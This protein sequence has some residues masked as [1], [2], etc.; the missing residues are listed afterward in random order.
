MKRV[1]PYLCMSVCVFD[2]NHDPKLGASNKT[3]I[4]FF[5]ENQSVSCL[6][7]ILLVSLL[8]SLFF[9]VYPSHV[10]CPSSCNV[11]QFWQRDFQ[12]Y[13]ILNANY[14]DFYEHFIMMNLVHVSRKKQPFKIPLCLSVKFFF[15]RL[16]ESIAV[17]FIFYLP[18]SSLIEKT[19]IAETF[20]ASTNKI[21]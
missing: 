16:H 9:S 14:N 13:I 4:S 2:N 21:K 3:H 6:I 17:V 11:E 20:S 8:H 12:F 7:L 5:G 19:E 18:H 1:S 15:Q 10:L